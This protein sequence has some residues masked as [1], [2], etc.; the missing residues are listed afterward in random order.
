MDTYDATRIVL[1]RIQNLDPEN[2]SKI[3]G[4]ILLQDHVENEMI[5][6]AFGPE[7]LLHSL[8]LQARKELGLPSTPSS[9]P[10]FLP[11][12]SL[13]RQNSSSSR[14]NLPS[15]L[16]IPNQASPFSPSLGPK[17]PDFLYPQQGLPNWEGSST[18][19]GSFGGKPCLFYGRGY[20]KN[21]NSCRF[22]HAGITDSGPVVGSPGKFETMEQC[23][24]QFLRSTSAQQQSLAA[25][26][27]PYSPVAAN[28]PMN[29]LPQQQQ[30]D[31]QSAA[32]AAAL[33]M[34]DDMHKFGPSRIERN[35][36]PMNPASRQIYLTFPAESTFNEDDVSRYFSNYGPV[37]DVRIPYQ[38]KRMFGFVTFLYPETV[39]AI[40]TKGNPHFI[41][42]SRVLVKPYKDK[43]K[44]PDKKQQHMPPMEKLDFLASGS[45][46]DLDPRGPYGPLPGARILGNTQ[47]TMW[48]RK[49]EEQANLE[50]ALELQGRRMMG[51]QLVDMN[52]QNHHWRLPSP[53]TILSPTH[54]KMALNQAL[55]PSDGKS[56]KMA[57]EK[58]LDQTKNVG[59]KEKESSF[60]NGT[61]QNAMGKESP[62][63]NE[64]SDLPKGP[65]HN[66]PDSPFASPKA[67]GENLTAFSDTAGTEEKNGVLRATSAD[68]DLIT[69]PFIPAASLKSCYYQVPV[70]RFSSHGAIKM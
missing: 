46:T 65:E 17:S 25:S 49:L 69:S 54:S 20:C 23:Q 55:I 61:D 27:F 28:R 62:K 45:P 30:I 53:A 43:G 14:H 57:E 32:A 35:D 58:Q 40:L 18:A 47:D 39:Q 24:E 26:T 50:Q 29:L 5:R 37:Q 42:E 38:H 70:P 68:N 4:F 2:A 34:G 8:V 51:L 10:A 33:M 15:P 44:V 19:S 3:M 16:S 6:L 12:V 1:S 9:R 36:Y 41:C 60:N 7:S 48:R 64:E 13:S 59:V 11:P 52:G 22:F 21:G 56:P 31:S 63:R 66:L 67:A